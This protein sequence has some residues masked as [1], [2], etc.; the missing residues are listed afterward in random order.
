[1]FANLSYNFTYC[2]KSRKKR[3]SKPCGLMAWLMLVSVANGLLVA[4]SD[5]VI[6]LVETCRRQVFDAGTVKETNR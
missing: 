2:S 5:Q 3:R 6:R 4:R 1:M